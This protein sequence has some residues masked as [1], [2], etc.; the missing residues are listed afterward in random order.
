MLLTFSPK[1]RL[2]AELQRCLSLLPFPFP[3]PFPG[4]AAVASPALLTSAEAA[5]TSNNGLLLQGLGSRQQ[6]N[7]HIPLLL[8]TGRIT[9]NVWAILS[10]NS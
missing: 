1:Q 6:R 10:I 7:L 8:T 5:T 3:F 2:V 4:T 9:T